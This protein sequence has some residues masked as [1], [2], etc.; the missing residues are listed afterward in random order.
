MEAAGLLRRAAQAAQ[1]AGRL[2]R[3]VGLDLAHGLA[4]DPL[5]RLGALL[6]DDPL[7][8]GE[9][10]EALRLSNAQRDRLVRMLA[11]EP[12]IT[13]ALDER[14]ARALVYRD[15]AAAVADRLRLAWAS[16]PEAPPPLALLALAA[17]WGPPVLPVTGEDILRLGVSRGPKVG[18]LL[19]RAEAAW[20][21]SDFTAGRDELLGALQEAS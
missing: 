9:T 10:A 4:A 3:L 13:P 19:R 12:S 18:E 7:V 21:D 20:V 17:S 16:E 5:L 8:A 15:G 2:E 6:P 1:D 14:S 11:P